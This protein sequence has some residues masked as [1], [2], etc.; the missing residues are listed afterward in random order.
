MRR[1]SSNNGRGM[2]STPQNSPPWCVTKSRSAET[3]HSTKPCMQACAR[4]R[5][6][7][8]S[9]ATASSTGS[10]LKYKATF[11]GIAAERANSQC[12]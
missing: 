1:I 6:T 2:K 9:T 11:A 4:W 5:A 10:K 3:P 8:S 12:T 7:L